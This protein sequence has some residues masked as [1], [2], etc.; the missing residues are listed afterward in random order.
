MYNTDEETEQ[1]KHTWRDGVF[2]YLFK[3]EVNFSQM[4]E[5]L[6]GKKISP[7]ELEFRDTSSVILAKDQKNDIAFIT[8]AG[9]FIFLVEHQHSKNLNMGLRMFMYYA[10]LLRIYIK[11]NELNIHGEK[12]VKFP[13]AE[14]YVAYSGKRPWNNDN[15]IDAGDVLISIKLVDINYDNLQK[16]KVVNTLHGYSY[17]LKQFL[18]HKTIKNQLPQLAVYSAFQDCRDNGYLLDYVD[19]EEFLAMVIEHWTIE[20]QLEDREA[21]GRE[22]ARAEERARAEAEKLEIVKRMLVDGVSKEAIAKYVGI[23]I[24]EIEAIA[25]VTGLAI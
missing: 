7:D 22:E 25:D 20:Q 9:D 16:T 14:F 8:K 17:L 13:K 18:Y 2:R 3:D 11:K 19:K 1:V 12:L 5:L 24:T 6:S 4:Y 15:Y 10:E 21:Y 23:D